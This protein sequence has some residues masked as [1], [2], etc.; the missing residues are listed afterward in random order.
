MVGEFQLKRRYVHL[1]PA[2][3]DLW[4]SWMDKNE[5]GWHSY[6]YDVH[7]GEGITPLAYE[8]EWERDLART[9]TQKRIDVVAMRQGVLW[10]FEVKPGAA[11]SAYGELLAYQQLYRRTFK[12]EGAIELAIVTD[13]LGPDD[14]WLFKDRGI[15]IFLV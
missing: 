12:Y 1:L 3:R 6:E 13:R 8:F 2:E 7:V 4:Q 14:E 15:H 9:L 10:I 11:M 5:Q